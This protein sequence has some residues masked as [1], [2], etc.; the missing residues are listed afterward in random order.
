MAM[1]FTTGCSR[2]FCRPLHVKVRYYSI[3]GI[4]LMIHSI[5]QMV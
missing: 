1:E 5:Y 4:D 2:A 3:N